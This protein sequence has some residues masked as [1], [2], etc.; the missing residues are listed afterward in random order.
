LIR[1]E[2]GPHSHSRLA[3]RFIL[4]SLGEEGAL[5]AS[6]SLADR[7]DDIEAVEPSRLF[8]RPL[9]TYSSKNQWLFTLPK[10]ESALCVAVGNRWSAVATTKQFV[11]IFTGRYRLFRPAIH[12]PSELIM[13]LMCSGIQDDIFAL[14]GPIVTLVG[15]G[16]LLAV[17]YH[18]C[19]PSKQNQTITYQVLDISRKLQISS[20]QL[21]ITPNSILTWAG[22][23]ET[24]MLFTM[25]SEGLVSGLAKVSA[26]AQCS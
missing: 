26:V 7:E 9:T 4:G 2:L 20:G 25:D 19:S 15:R 1:G 10:G 6:A 21:S 16:T 13:R 18:S 8:Y 24:G 12:L 22:F 14:P 11:R 3:F 23:N 17:F 5:F